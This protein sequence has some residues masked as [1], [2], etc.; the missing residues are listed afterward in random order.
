MRADLVALVR[1]W[2]ARPALPALA[3]LVLTIGVGAGATVL[4]ATY[5]ALLRPL[6][7]PRADQL[8]VVQTDFPGMKLRGM[9][10][11]GPEA[12]ELAGFARSFAAT[13]F[14]YVDTA[15]IEIDGEPRRADV[16]RVS[17]GLI[18]ALRA[19]PTT[20]RIFTA[21][22]DV[23][24]G[25]CR[26]VVSPRF[27]DDVLG[28]AAQALGRTLGID[29]DACEVIG[30]WPRRV[31]L[32]ATPADIWAPLH[33]DV[34]APTSNR[35]N[36]AFTV[37]ARLADGV[38]L[39]GARADVARAVEGWTTATG[40]FHSPSPKFHPLS[41]TPMVDLVRG[42]VRGTAWVLLLSVATVL[43]VTIANASA[44]LVADAD[45]RWSEM[46]IRAALGADRRRL[47]RMQAA[48]AVVLG[49]LSAVL[50]AIAA[51]SG[52]RVV[53]AVAPPALARL[54]VTLPAWQIA[55][56][57]AGV[58]AIAAIVCSLLQASRIPWHS[59]TGALGGDTRTGTATGS[60]QRLRRALVAVEVALAVALVAG[61]ALMI[62][63]VWRLVN[64]D[65]GFRPDGVVRAQVNLPPDRYDTR[66][67]IDAFYDAVTHALRQQPGVT[68]AGAVT[69]LLP[70][71][72]PN[73]T[74]I[75]VSGATGDPHLGTPPI[76][77]MQFLTP[78]AFPALGLTLRRGRLPSATDLGTA[79]PIVVINERA[80]EVYFA[81]REALGGQ[82]R[83]M[84]AKL[85]WLT[86]V[87][88]VADARQNGVVRDA[89]TEMFVPL[90]QAENAFGRGDFT[91]DLNLV[92]RLADDRSAAFAP[93]LRAA[94]R[95]VDPGAAV[96]EV[97]AMTTVVGRGIAGPRFLMMILG[98]F[99]VVSL[100]LAAVGVYGIV[101]HS[102][103][104]RTRE[105]GVRRSL[106]AS[107][108]AIGV[109]IARQVMALVTGGLVAGLT[110]AIFSAR[111]L[112]PFTFQTDVAHP[113]RLAAIAAAMIV[114]ALL[115]SARPLF[116]ALRVDPAVVLK[117]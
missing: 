12:F 23:P 111:L 95:E 104:L 19:A 30:V 57:A 80:A 75:V 55:A 70:E 10:L 94:V 113:V 56:A 63:S 65:L 103:M 66:A 107:G 41:L 28:G 99:A 29:G 16:A 88:V 84:G 15:L 21:A 72:R 61:S 50:G 17:A 39:D 77:F 6:P 76:Q 100:L 112:S 108:S 3:L 105:I 40:Q 68:A 36:H 8:V 51:L 25:P 47:W 54:D 114:I 110:L 58:A 79:Q 102:V 11:S 34:K 101:G 22:D 74:S 69:G 92:V 117:Q 116:R 2:R 90:P 24:R 64:V 48:D 98:G 9:G 96:S 53:A 89:G 109:L 7:Y 1:R 5:A 82:L 32:L 38:T 52:V 31:A 44:L 62:E 106:G 18:D 27:A 49:A 59:L 85:P 93:I 91:R 33:Y 97:E 73:N 60:R 13:G 20:G 42:P 86:V 87:G 81:G 67:R 83:L 26:V 78:D 4:G 45:Q 71:R 46:L 37:L 14:G 35:S 115:A 43:I